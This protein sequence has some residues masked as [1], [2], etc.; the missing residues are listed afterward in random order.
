M[1]L[2]LGRFGPSFPAPAEV[3]SK[4]GM[5]R[6]RQRFERDLIRPL[7]GNRVLAPANW[8]W[9]YV[10]KPRKECS[11]L[12]E[13]R[14][15]VNKV[16]HRPLGCYGQLRFEFIILLFATERDDEFDPPNACETALRRKT[17]VLR[18]RRYSGVRH[19]SWS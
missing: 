3:S 4:N 13:I 8:D 18:D 6:K 14:F 16:Q 15:K 17:L 7:S 1:V 9:P 2:R 10:G 19:K 5:R 11:G 12:I